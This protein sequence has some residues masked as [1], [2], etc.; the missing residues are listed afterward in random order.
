MSHELEE[1]NAKIYAMVKDHVSWSVILHE[2]SLKSTK[3]I[4]VI[5]KRYEKRSAPRNSQPH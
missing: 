5:K 1:R 3:S 2:F 4:W